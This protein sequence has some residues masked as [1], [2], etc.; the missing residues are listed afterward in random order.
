MQCEFANKPNKYLANL[1]HCRSHTQVISSMK[2]KEGICHHDN[3]AI[4]TIFQA[5]Y[6]KLYSSQTD[7]TP[8]DN[9]NISLAKLYIPEL[10]EE[11]KQA[12]NKPIESSEIFKLY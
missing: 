11:Q 9:R 12:L 1:L 5:L 6:K 4:N 10:T 3:T 8:G 2:D 7:L